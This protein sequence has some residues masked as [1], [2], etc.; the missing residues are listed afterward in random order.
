MTCPFDSDEMEDLW[1]SDECAEDMSARVAKDEILRLR[2]LL[3]RGGLDVPAVL[4]NDARRRVES[5]P[6]KWTD[7]Y[8]VAATS[9]CNQRGVLNV[10][11]ASDVSFWQTITFCRVGRFAYDI[12]CCGSC[13]YQAEIF[14]G[15]GRI[16]ISV[17]SCDL[18]TVAAAALSEGHIINVSPEMLNCLL[19]CVLQHCIKKSMLI[20]KK[21]PRCESN[22]LM[23]SWGA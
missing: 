13:C 16:G 7:A 1:N 3:D 8:S 23:E 20:G 2:R 12:T 21:D 18:S 10:H 4:V 14:G 11:V 9:A 5:D 17:A 6:S 22:N 19:H 15:E